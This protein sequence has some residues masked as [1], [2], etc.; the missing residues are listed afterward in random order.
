M[1]ATL[2]LRVFPMMTH[3]LLRTFAVLAVAVAAPR[4]AVAE[5]L[6]ELRGAF[7]ATPDGFVF[8]AA[9]GYRVRAPAAARRAL[10]GAWWHFSGDSSLRGVFLALLQLLERR[11]EFSERGADG[12]EEMVARRWFK[13]RD[14]DE[15]TG[16]D[17]PP[18]RPRLHAEELRRDALKFGWIDAIVNV[19]DGRLLAAHAEGHDMH[20][21][22]DARPAPDLADVL[23][24]RH[25]RDADARRGRAR[26][27][28]RAPRRPRLRET[29]RT[30]SRRQAC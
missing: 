17:R 11:G 2:P 27:T 7:E 5:P 10:D 16:A 14:F 30:V 22:A 26:L 9:R 23:S 19:S 3:G 20:H 29:P 12:A 28:F 21:G 1:Q 4:L 25:W 13:E 18:R 24:A 8:D 6:G 15:T